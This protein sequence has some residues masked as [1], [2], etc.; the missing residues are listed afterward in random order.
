MILK[1]IFLVDLRKKLN[2]V[3]SWGIGE[4][5]WLTFYHFAFLV[6]H[7]DWFKLYIIISILDWSTDAV[8]VITSSNWNVTWIEELNLHCDFIVKD[9]LGFGKLLINRCISKR[10]S[11]FWS[12]VL[13]E[14]GI[15]YHFKVYGWLF[16]VFYAWL[17]KSM[18]ELKIYNSFLRKALDWESCIDFLDFFILIKS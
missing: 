14:S 12:K 17:R 15:F 4:E 18:R 11:D 16:E 3:R 5:H 2:R 6:F 10:R 1:L 9:G 7:F 13:Q 8:T